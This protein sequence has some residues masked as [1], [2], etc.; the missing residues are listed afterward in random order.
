MSYPTSS[1]FFTVTDSSNSF[2]VQYPSFVNAIQ[3][4]ISR[5]LNQPNWPQSIILDEWGFIIPRKEWNQFIP[6]LKNEANRLIAACILFE[7]KTKGK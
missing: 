3:C 2:P 6:T 7:D 1:Q 5:D 4:A